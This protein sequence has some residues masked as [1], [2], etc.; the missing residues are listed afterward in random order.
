M[1]ETSAAK[2]RSVN[3]GDIIEINGKKYKSQPSS[4]TAFNFALRHYDSRDELPDGYF[5]SIRLVETGDIV[6]HSV[7]DIW[8]AVLTAQSK[9]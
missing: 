6:L 9:E 4:T 2:P 5:I 8:D 3:V 7:Q 1:S